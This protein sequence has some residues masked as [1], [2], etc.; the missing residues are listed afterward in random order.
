MQLDILAHRQVGG[1]AGV[2]L[3]DVGDGPKLVRLQ[4]AVG[5]ANAHHEE[6]QRLPFSVFAADYADAVALGVHA[7]PA[8]ICAQPFRRDGIE[9]FAGELADV[10][11]AFPRILLPLKALDPLCLRLFVSVTAFAIGFLGHKKTHRQ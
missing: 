2:F 10:V 9:A 6:R 8:E 5:N 3:G 4:Q 7:P 1:P 11:K